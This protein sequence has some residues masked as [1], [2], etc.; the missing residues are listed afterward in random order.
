MNEDNNPAASKPSERHATLRYERGTPGKEND[1]PSVVSCNWL[2]DGDYAVYL[3]AIQPPAASQ[4]SDREIILLADR[5]LK[6]IDTVENETIDFARAILAATQPPAA[7]QP[8][9]EFQLETYDAGL[10]ND[11]GGGKVEWWQDYI[12]NELSRA[13]GFYQS[14]CEPA[15]SQPTDGLER[16][17][18]Q[19]DE[20]A[21][22]H[23]ESH[24]REENEYAAGITDALTMI[25]ASLAAVQRKQ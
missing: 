7:S 19:L 15:A 14:Q 12:R 9:D 3:A 21:R 8:S 25:R 20:R 11:Y 17:F 18:R 24:D 22:E 1:M 5:Y 4:P 23:A 2:P 10:L 13:H 16:A 6:G